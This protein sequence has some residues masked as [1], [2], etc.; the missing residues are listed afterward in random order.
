MSIEVRRDYSTSRSLIERH[1]TPK[2]TQ[3][4]INPL[5]LGSY[6]DSLMKEREEMILYIQKLQ[7]Y[8]D[9]LININGLCPYCDLADCSSDHK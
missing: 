1:F 8:I 4:L 5:Q 3:T 7:D 2:E 9:H 6:V